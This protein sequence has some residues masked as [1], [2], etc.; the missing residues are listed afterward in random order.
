[1][2]LRLLMMVGFIAGG[3]YAANAANTTPGAGDENARKSDVAGGVFHHES[4]KPLSNVTVT[5]YSANKKEKV[6]TT[7]AAGSFSFDDLK[8]GT[9]TFV[10][11]K[12]GY[13]KVVREKT[14]QRVDQASELNVLLEEHSTYDFTPGPAHF[15]EF[16]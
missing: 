11:E 13:R 1:M 6:V 10:F 7:T 3:S 9:Y 15:F 8:P 4:H 2:K 14:I 5:A 12:A 16:Q